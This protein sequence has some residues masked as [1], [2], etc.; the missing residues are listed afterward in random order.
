S[1]CRGSAGRSKPAASRAIIEASAATAASTARY[2]C[3]RVRTLRRRARVSATACSR[4]HCRRRRS[5]P[6][7]ARWRSRTSKPPAAW[8]RTPASRRK[9]RAVSSSADRAPP[10]RKRLSYNKFRQTPILG[11]T[12]LG[13]NGNHVGT[14]SR[15]IEAGFGLD[16]RQHLSL[17]SST[18]E[19]KRK[20]N[21]NDY[22]PRAR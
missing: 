5:G 7:A 18:K 6:A 8:D 20:K 9:K 15:T 10:G 21:N 13:Q 19:S 22:I 11:R 2:R 1:R 16:A 4:S 3:P 14:T 12:G 17:L